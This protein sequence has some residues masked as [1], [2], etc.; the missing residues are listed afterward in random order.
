MENEILI[1]LASAPVVAALLQVFKPT[2]GIPSRF[3]PAVTLVLGIAWNVGIRA[4]EISDA[5]W[6]SAAMLGVMSGLAAG[7][8]YSA[9]KAATGQ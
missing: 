7:G 3:V 4:G 6:A 9:T 1:G 5:T 2:F 8:F